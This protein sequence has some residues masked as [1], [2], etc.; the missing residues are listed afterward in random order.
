[1]KVGKKHSLAGSINSKTGHLVSQRYPVRYFNYT[2]KL[3]EFI[4][5]SFF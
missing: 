1:M 3:P 4:M 2:I 5:N